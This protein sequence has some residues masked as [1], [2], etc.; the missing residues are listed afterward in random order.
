MHGV[1]ER[2]ACRKSYRIRWDW[3]K[4]RDMRKIMMALGLVVA[5]LMGIGT[6]SAESKPRPVGK[7]AAAAPIKR[8]VV[9][10]FHPCDF[11]RSTVIEN[12][13]ERL[14]M[15]VWAHDA[16][17]VDGSETPAGPVVVVGLIDEARVEGAGVAYIREG[18]LN[19]EAN[20]KLRD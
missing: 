13:T 9:R 11:N 6:A 10:V 20:Y 1:R 8:A 15:R 16:Y 17:S 12:A 14:C 5:V 7:I 2:R 4:E 18:L 19:E 3:E